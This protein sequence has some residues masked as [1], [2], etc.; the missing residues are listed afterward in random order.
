VGSLRGAGWAILNLDPASHR[1]MNF[2]IDEHDTGHA[3]GCSPILVMDVWEHA[4][5]TDYGTDRASYIEAFMANVD[6]KEIEKRLVVHSV[7][8]AHH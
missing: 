4:F 6:W 1:L 3:A 2:W 7:E 8:V 5:M